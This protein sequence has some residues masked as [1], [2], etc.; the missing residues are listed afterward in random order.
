MAAPLHFDPN[1]LR[2]WAAGSGRLCASSRRAPICLQAQADC[3]RT[4]PARAHAFCFIAV[5]LLYLPA[6]AGNF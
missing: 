3:S 1:Q 4:A 2:N 6:E 5:A